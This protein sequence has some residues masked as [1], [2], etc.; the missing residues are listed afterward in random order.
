MNYIKGKYRSSIFSN[1]NGYTIG[2]FKVKE[3]NDEELKD[4][5]NKTITFTGYFSDLN[6][7]DT[8]ILY[9]ELIYHDRYGY[10]YKVTNYEKVI[11]VGKEAVIEFLS[12]SLIQ[13]SGEKTAIKI[14]ESLG[15]DAVNK[16]KENYDNLLLVPG[17]TEKRAKKIYDSIMSYSNIDEV[18]IK[19]KEK[20]FS[21]QESL[22]LLKSYNMDI[23]A[24]V[25][26]NPY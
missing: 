23:I 1:A 18:I 10:Q 22:K 2:L 9:G 7:E 20:G 13:G 24:T 25:N 3:T 17:M 11:P 16:I 4:Y 21:L 14:V 15:E 6:I 5:V 8:F 12:S 26:N 19:L